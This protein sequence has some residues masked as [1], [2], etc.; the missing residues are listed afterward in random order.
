M[1]YSTAIEPVTVLKTKSARLINQVRETGQPLVIT[2][3]G[4]ARAVLQDVESYEQQQQALLLLK[5]LAQGDQEL[6]A[7]QRLSHRRAREHFR[8]TL[9]RMKRG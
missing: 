2:V 4:K 5:V 9:E 3:N 8:T 1:K 6:R 7:G